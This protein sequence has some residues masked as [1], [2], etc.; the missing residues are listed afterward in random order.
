MQQPIE[1]L[2]LRCSKEEVG[3]EPLLAH[4]AWRQQQLYAHE[5]FEDSPDFLKALHDSMN[6]IRS[7][8][9]PLVVGI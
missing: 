4:A 9:P 6:D 5:D 7:W 1:R 2:Y 8:E 3:E